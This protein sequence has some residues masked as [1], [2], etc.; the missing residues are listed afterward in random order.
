NRLAVGS[1]VGTLYVLGCL[2]ILYVIPALWREAISPTFAS[3][4]G[5][6]G[7]PA[8]RMLGGRGVGVVVILFGRAAVGGDPPH[9]IRAGIFVGLVGVFVIGLFTRWIGALLESSL[10]E[11]GTLVGVSVTVAVGAV[12]LIAGAMAFFRPGFNRWLMQ[13]EDQ[14]WFSASA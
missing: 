11:S 12:L 4:A 6:G 10:G 14:G 13:V 7:D 2:A 8:L 5:G 3:A 9:G 1:L